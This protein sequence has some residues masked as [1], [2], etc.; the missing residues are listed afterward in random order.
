MNRGVE[1]DT[2]EPFV[3]P[4]GPVWRLWQCQTRHNRVSPKTPKEHP[5]TI[6]GLIPNAPPRCLTV[7]L[8]LS[9]KQLDPKAVHGF[10]SHH[11]GGSHYALGDGSVRFLSENIDINTYHFLG[12]RKD[13]EILKTF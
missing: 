3:D 7:D 11:P 1:Y 5:E 9:D 10:S 2:G 12:N 6:D 13:G 4:A 8:E